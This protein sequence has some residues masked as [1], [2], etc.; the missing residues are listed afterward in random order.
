MMR[1]CIP[2]GGSRLG[3]KIVAMYRCGDADSSSISV[4]LHPYDLTFA[5]DLDGCGPG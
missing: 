5:G 1:L 2:E 4:A 3:K